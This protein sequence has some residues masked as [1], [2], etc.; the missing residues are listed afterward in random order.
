MY[1]VRYLRLMCVKKGEGED[2]SNVILFDSI[3]SNTIDRERAE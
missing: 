2:E 1:Y 3:Q